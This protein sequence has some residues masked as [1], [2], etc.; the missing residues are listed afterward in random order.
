MASRRLSSISREQ[1]FGNKMEMKWRAT[2]LCHHTPKAGQGV[3]AA[4]RPGG[5][6]DFIVIEER[7]CIR[8]IRH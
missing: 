7:E 5:P 6:V 4:R 1:S 3:A 2:N 8:S